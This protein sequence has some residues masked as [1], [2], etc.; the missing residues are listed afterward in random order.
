MP[1]KNT[2]KFK[3]SDA[4][5]MSFIRFFESLEISDMSKYKRMSIDR[6]PKKALISPKTSCLNGAIYLFNCCT[7]KKYVFIIFKIKNNTTNTTNGCF[8]II[9]LIHILSFYLYYY[10]TVFKLF[11]AKA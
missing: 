10:N 6:L 1:S 8:L 3:S 2:N 5:M 4:I 7:V 11:Y 9:L